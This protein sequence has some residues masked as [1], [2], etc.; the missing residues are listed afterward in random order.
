MDLPNVKTYLR[1]TN[2]AE[3]EGWDSG[4]AWLGGGTWLFSQAQPH[5]TT[6]VD[7]EPLGWS[8]LQVTSTGLAIGATCTHQQLLEFT[9]PDRWSGISALHGA[10]SHLGSFKV[11]RMATVG[12]N[13][14]LAL[15]AST[16]APVMVALG[17][18]Y[19]IWR[20][21]G[22]RDRVSALE[23]QTGAQQTILRSGDALRRIWIPGENLEWRVNFQRIGITTAG[24]ALSIVV[25]AYNPQT[26]QVRFGVGGCIPAPRLLE[27]AGVP[28]A[29]EMAR[30]LDERLPRADIIDDAYGSARYRR[31][32][33]GVLMQ[34][35]I[36]EL[37][38]GILDFRF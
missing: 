29:E 14:C 3:I 35:G 24:V 36:R 9:F 11:S 13:L 23:F 12:G 21:D 25:G 15:P 34:R 7:L 4:W 33:T 16:F 5:L 20:S 10:V 6:L 30:V 26:E 28:T 18:S 32:M 31:Q 8:E 37:G 27:F 19:E 1:P 22:S 38:M 17:A 2:L